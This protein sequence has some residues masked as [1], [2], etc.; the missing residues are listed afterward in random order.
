MF[1]DSIGFVLNVLKLANDVIILLIQKGEMM[2]NLLLDKQLLTERQVAELLQKSVQSLR[3]DR[4]LGRGLAY[5]K[6]G[7]SIRYR[8][9]DIAEYIESH[10]FNPAD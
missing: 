7:R 1:I 3:N 8:A 2:T 9:E 6:I 4:S 5:V 10:R